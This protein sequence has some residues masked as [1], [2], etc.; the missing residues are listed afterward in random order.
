MIF[1]EYEAYVLKY[2]QEYGP[3]TLVLLECGSFYE[4]Y[5]DGS[6]LV[7]MRDVSDMLNIQVSRRNKQI[8]EVNRVNYEMAGFPSH[9]LQKFIGILLQHQ[10]TVVVVSQV[11]A[12]PNPKRAVTEVISPGTTMQPH[13]LWDSNELMVLYLE[14]HTDMK[15]GLPIL[16]VGCSGID[17]TTGRSYVLE[18]TS[19]PH[20]MS[21]PLDEVYRIM[22]LHQPREVYIMSEPLEFMQAS[23][24]HD[25]LELDRCY[26]HN[27][28]GNM[29]GSLKKLAI[30]KEILK[31]VW[32]STGLLSPIEYIG[33]ERK[34]CGLIS[35]V[36]L[37][38]FAVHH[39]ETLLK[40]IQPPVLVDE[41]RTLTLSYN[42]AQQLDIIH[43]NDR[44]NGTVL[45]LLNNCKTSVGK[46]YMKMR[47]LSPWTN[48]SQ[49]SVCHDMV[50][51]CLTSNV[52]MQI[53]EKLQHVYDVERLFRRLDMNIIH[54]LEIDHLYTSLEAVNAAISLFPLDKVQDIIPHIADIKQR[55]ESMFDMDK[56]MMYNR[57]DLDASIFQVG[58][59]DDI[60]E[61]K[62]LC[63][64]KLGDLQT[65][66]KQL[67]VGHDFFKLEHNEK[68]GYFLSITPKR[69]KE[70]TATKKP[71]SAYESWDKFHVRTLTS[72]SKVS[73]ALLDKAS[74]E[75]MGLQRRL[76]MLSQV[77]F[78]ECIEHIQH[79]SNPHVQKIVEDLA[80]IDYITT[81]AYNAFKYRLSKP[82]LQNPVHTKS[83][84]E[85][86]GLRH[87]IISAMQPHLENV[88]NDV[89]I[90]KDDS[91]GLLLYGINSAG[92]SSLMKA[93]GIAVIMAQAGMF[94]PCDHMVI[95]P[96]DKI[97]TRI[98]SQDDIQRGHSTFTKEIMELRNILKRATSNS[99]VIGDELC[100]GTENI[101]AL[102]IVSAG[103]HTLASKGVSFVFATHLHD[104]VNIPEVQQLRNVRV[105]HLS[106][107]YDPDIKKLVYDRTL[108]PGNGSTMYG[109]EVCRSLDLDPEFL[110]LANFIRQRFVSL[111]TPAKQSH[112]NKD[113]VVHMCNV[114]KVHPACEVHHIQPQHMADG[115]GYIKDFHK[116]TKHNL[117]ALCDSCH[118]AV[119]HGNLKVLGYVQTMD[120]VELKTST[121]SC[122]D[123]VQ[124]AILDT[125]KKCH[126][127]KYKKDIYNYIQK[128]TGVTLYKI[129]Q[130][131][132][133]SKVDTTSNESH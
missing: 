40:D 106:V 30:Q 113:V 71:P 133:S 66:V 37:V 23:K 96:Y 53:R 31:Q 44:Q 60:D 111:S 92:K 114:C 63:A 10:Y 64:G 6:G 13:S 78:K 98:F 99:L 48:P 57:D 62:L 130:V 101:S 93:I 127:F 83:F 121:A 59:F 72:S 125:Y 68:D 12:P 126:H 79:V 118:K 123:T 74:H 80:L 107:K 20:D 104:L 112:F 11:T 18:V 50:E 8:I 87:I 42:C 73:H 110:S 95:A 38:E 55:I 115:D 9:T 77:R 54:P 16:S 88:P 90:G 67:N 89:I 25:H 15:T 4:I 82:N 105:F 1:D 116:N 34:P 47:I 84:A 36:K 91:D 128:H 45:H 102:A 46:R 27:H 49:M 120:G 14:E 108:R 117:T 131:L 5:N 109:I 7:D 39:N 17:V 41:T 24:I 51:K 119:H 61:L 97:F 75:I 3:R 85:M 65:V 86:K 100:S 33:L 35:F 81:N 22:S 56:L 69:W 2:R 52:H 70:L 76:N 26:L 19:R 28:I 129:R 132:R 124:D 58:V 29:Q 43:S 21:Y 32:P 94:V 122:H 103:I